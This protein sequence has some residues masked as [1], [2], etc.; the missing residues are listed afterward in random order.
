MIPSRFF[1][2]CF[3]ELAALIALTLLPVRG[4]AE[5][6]CQHYRKEAPNLYKILCTNGGAVTT[7][8]AGASST[9]SSAFSLNSA[10]LPTEPSSYGLETIVSSFKTPDGALQLSPTFSIVKGFQRFG[11]GVST[12]SNNTFFGNDIVQRANGA[13]TIDSFSPHEPAKGAFAN[14]NLGTSLTVFEPDH[15]PTLRLGFSLRYNKTTD[16]LGGGPGLMLNWNRFTLGGGYTQE[17]VSNELPRVKFVNLMASARVS[18][19]EFE[20]THLSNVGGYELKPIHI[21]STTA[22]IQKLSLTFAVRRLNYYSE[23]DVTQTHFAVQYLFSK[24]FSAGYLV[25]Y[26]PGTASIGTQFY[27]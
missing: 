16:T 27:L 17:R 18:I 15:G 12:S 5:T 2:F 22:S 13:S 1:L 4:Y 8:P 21:L 23:G 9:F 7:K 3:F 24:R 14:L 25:N 26:I 11:T 10:S 19:L 20:Y 6:V